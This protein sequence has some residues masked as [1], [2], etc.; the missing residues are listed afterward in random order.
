MAPNNGESEKKVR[1]KLVK[2][3]MPQRHASMHFPES[4]KYGDDAQDDVTATNGRPAQYMNQSI[5]SMVTAAGSKT[6]FHARFDDGSSDS[7]GDTENDKTVAD[8]TPAGIGLPAEVLASKDHGHAVGRT[9]EHGGKSTESSPRRH[10][11][12]SLPKLKLKTLKERNYM[13]QSSYLPS[14]HHDSL[15]QSPKQV[16]PRDAPVMSQ[17]LAAQAHF[18][19][20]VE[21]AVEEKTANL[22]DVPT[23]TKGPSSLAT[24]LMEIFGFRSPEEVIS[25]SCSER[26]AAPVLL[27]DIRLEYPCWLMQSVLLQGYMYITQAHICFYAY[28]PKKSVSKIYSQGPD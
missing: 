6:N 27:T 25:G 7:E 12:I 4:L 2:K 26:M 17:M 19:P 15:S 22:L 16:T 24:R 14:A 13:S 8:G 3:K 23:S 11:R 1:R 20:A 5:F 9:K 18:S 28:L 10:S 21:K